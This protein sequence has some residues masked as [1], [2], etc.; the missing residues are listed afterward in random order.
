MKETFEKKVWEIFDRYDIGTHEDESCVPAADEISQLLNDLR[1][2][3]CLKCGAYTQ[4]H[5]GACNGCKWYGVKG[6][7]DG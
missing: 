6:E 2:E 5:E 3:L 1:N 4:E 7:N